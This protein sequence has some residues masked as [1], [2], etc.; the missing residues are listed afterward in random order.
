MEGVAFAGGISGC[1]SGRSLAVTF[2][3]LAMGKIIRMRTQGHWPNQ[4]WPGGKHEF[5]TCVTTRIKKRIW[6]DVEY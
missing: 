3:S 2:S 4:Y 5:D 6:R 1:F